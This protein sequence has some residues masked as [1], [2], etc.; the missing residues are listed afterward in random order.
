MSSATPRAFETAAVPGFL[1]SKADGPDTT[2]IRVT[3]SASTHPASD[4]VFSIGTACQAQTGAQMGFLLQTLVGANS[5]TAIPLQLYYP[6]NGSVVTLTA[7]Q[8]LLVMDADHTVVVVGGGVV[9]LGSGPDVLAPPAA[10]STTYP[11]IAVVSIRSD[12]TMCCTQLQVGNSDT[13]FVSELYN[14]IVVD[15]WCCT[16][17][18]WLVAATGFQAVA[19]SP[20]SVP[21]QDDPVPFPCPAAP[22]VLVVPQT[23]LRRI[24]M[25]TLMPD[26]IGTEGDLYVTP[27]G[28]P[29]YV[30]VTPDVPTASVS[31]ACTS[32]MVVI[33]AHA[34]VDDDKVQSFLWAA[35]P[36]LALLQPSSSTGFND[37][38]TGL[39]PLTGD[40]QSLTLLRVFALPDDSTVVVGRAYADPATAATPCAVQVLQYTP[41]TVLDLGFAAGGV[42]Q[43]A[44]SN[45]VGGTYAVDASLLVQGPAGPV[46]GPGFVLYVVGNSFFSGAGGPFDP[47]MQ[48]I[49]PGF[50]FGYLNVTSSY[51]PIPFAIEVR[52]YACG[53]GI[54]S[55][56]RNGPTPALT[57]PT[58]VSNACGPQLVRPLFTQMCGCGAHWAS[59]AAMTSAFSL[60]V[61]GDTWFH[62]GCPAQGS[63]L[64]DVAV[65]LA[66]WAT[67]ARGLSSTGLSG[68]SN[69][70]PGI[71]V[72]PCVPVDCSPQLLNNTPVCMP[73]IVADTCAGTVTVDTL[74]P[75]YTTLKVRGPVLVGCMCEDDLTTQALQGMIR[76]DPVAKTLLVFDGTEWRTI[77]MS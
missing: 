32:C 63:Y 6:S 46:V 31:L 71:P 19:R 56:G 30:H 65:G 23:I 77:L 5:Q 16:G 4:R 9:D 42:L 34:L 54:T 36:D 48:Y 74:C 60:V 15:P 11:A 20:A 7:P 21:A 75:P 38:A 22:A 8:A 72:A 67:A 66:P 52:G 68:L 69:R 13:A 1:G 45:I 47:P 55:R 41:D 40:T 76:Y 28:A 10:A 61:T 14:D 3:R 35:T 64:F 26:P 70:M 62:L 73:A 57:N 59:S 58:N 18:A 53:T 29:T 50:T 37:P 43:W 24:N 25:E 39:L 12:G 2:L 33:G 51:D 49:V 44:N 27:V 17:N